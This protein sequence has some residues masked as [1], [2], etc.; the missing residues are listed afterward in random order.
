MNSIHD[1]SNYDV[2]TALGNKACMESNMK[3]YKMNV[4]L[5]GMYAN[6]TRSVSRHNKKEIVI[7]GEIRKWYFSCTL[8]D[9]KKE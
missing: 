8:S 2:I 1:I 3:F 6:E 5:V 9:S 4:I 7:R